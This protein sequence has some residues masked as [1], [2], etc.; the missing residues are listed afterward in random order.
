MKRFNKNEKESNLGTKIPGE[1]IYSEICG[2]FSITDT[3][4]YHYFQT[5]I[6]DFTRMTATFLMKTRT[7]TLSNI[8]IYIAWIN[9]RGY[10]FKT[11]RTGQGTE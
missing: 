8:E 1:L 7:K 3:N 2:L 9:A 6:D 11:F 5:R 10:Y 4:E